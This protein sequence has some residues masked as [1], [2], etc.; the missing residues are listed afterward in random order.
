MLEALTGVD[1]VVDFLDGSKFRVQ[2]QKG[3]CVKPDSLMTIPEKGLPFHKTPFKFGNLFVLFTVKFP[4]SLGAEEVASV[5][6]TLKG[7]KK[8]NARMSDASEVVN[9][10]PFSA[11]QKN[12]DPRGGSKGDHD[13][14]EDDD[15]RMRG[16]GQRV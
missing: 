15:P 9:L 7:M 3:H 11:D 12:T 13:E 1:F 16:G 2:T 8:K 14:E 6:E 4:D 10:I 5:E